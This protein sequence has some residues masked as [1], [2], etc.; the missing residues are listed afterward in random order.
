MDF[1]NTYLPWAMFVITAIIFV[2]SLFRF[3]IV[4]F[5]RT[6]G[7]Y[8]TVTKAIHC[9]LP[10][11]LG[12]LASH[13][14]YQNINCIANRP[15]FDQKDVEEI[16]LGGFPGYLYLCTFLILVLF[17]AVR[18]YQDSDAA[19]KIKTAYFVLVAVVL[20]VW[21]IFLI[22]FCLPPLQS[23]WTT[24]HMVE[25]SFAS[26]AQLL[27]SAC[28]LFFGLKMWGRLRESSNPRLQKMHQTIKFLTIF[29]TIILALRA[30]YLL[31]MAFTPMD[32]TSFGVS[33]TFFSIL[34]DLIPPIVLMWLLGQQPPRTSGA[35]AFLVNQSYESH[36]YKESD[37]L[38]STDRE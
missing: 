6:S 13:R 18:Y 28:F 26:A 19:E 16:S 37:S 22:L 9:L 8:P 11:S 17:W 10:F 30:I 35:K 29:E 14:L 3:Y 20:S 5:S 38:L 24:I 7:H 27:G 31:I 2:V 15:T 4:V 36:S 25:V 1:L 33:F 34:F 23:N 12:A 32:I 21:L